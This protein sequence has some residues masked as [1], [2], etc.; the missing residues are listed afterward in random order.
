[1]TNLKR[2]NSNLYACEEDGARN[3][4]LWRALRK[5]RFKKARPDKDAQFHWLITEGADITDPYDLL[6]LR[7][8]IARFRKTLAPELLDV[9]DLFLHGYTPKQVVLRTQWAQPTVYR[10]LKQIKEKF[11]TFYVEDGQ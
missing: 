2:N 1:M 3:G 9:F 4:P 6:E 11:K 8:D 5:E 7:I 10:K